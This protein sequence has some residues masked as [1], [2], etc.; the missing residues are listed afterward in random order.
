[1]GGACAGVSVWH[2]QDTGE[3]KRALFQPMMDM[4]LCPGEDKFKG[5]ANFGLQT[6]W[7]LL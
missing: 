1:M 5:H 3:K 4:L 6:R 7:R 2:G